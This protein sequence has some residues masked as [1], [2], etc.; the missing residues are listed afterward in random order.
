MMLFRHLV[1]TAVLLAAAGA[2]AREAPRA[3]NPHGNLDLDCVLCHDEGSWQVS[4]KMEDFDHAA[5]GF[6]LEGRHAQAHCRD[7]H[8][9]PR[10]AF[11]GTACADCHADFHKGRLGLDCGRCHT[12]ERWVQRSEQRLAHDA[13]GFPLVGAHARVDCDACH[14]GPL[15]GEYVGTPSDCVFCH[16]AD[17]EATRDPDH[18]TAGFDT[19]CQRC[20]SPY[21]STWGGGDFSHPASFPL[22]GAHG[23]LE[24]VACH[25]DGFAGAVAD[26]FTCHDDDYQGA[27]DPDHVA[28]NFPTT[29]AICHTTTAWEPAQFDHGLTG[30]P[31]TGA[32]RGLDCLS[33]HET[34]YQNT[35]ADCYACH[36][37]DFEGTA[38]PDHVASGFG[39]DCATCHTATAWEPSTWDHDI[40]FPIYSGRHRGEWDTCADC[41]V[42]PSSYTVFECIF[43]H[44]HNQADTDRDHDEVSN[45]QYS[46]TACL[47]CHPRGEE[48]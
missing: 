14:R 6:P 12:P 36:Q 27:G 22:T 1:L 7:C 9:D 11:V 46:S 30:F 31:L 13:T 33:C 28:G 37:A 18:R 8:E 17:Y 21:A 34:G 3:G 45:Y 32:H 47:D 25:T 24:C 5:T 41:H 44:E 20:H 26:C 38:D 2:L 42:V 15:A 35:P 19:D 4:G 29:C 43:C 16:A 39:T 23:G 10:F 40:L 48:D